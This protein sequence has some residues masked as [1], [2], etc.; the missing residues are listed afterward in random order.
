MSIN[1]IPTEI[2][3]KILENVP[4]K[5]ASS[6]LR[7]NREW[8]NVYKYILQRDEVFELILYTDYENWEIFHSKTNAKYLKRKVINFCK[9]F[10]INHRLKLRKTLKLLNDESLKVDELLKDKK[11]KDFK[12]NLM[13]L[14]DI[15][16]KKMQI[17]RLFG[18]PKYLNL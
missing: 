7:V 1:T 18:C 10:G 9:A 13:K 17:E 3:V 5:D 12:K 4:I 16:M 14:H 11:D 8:N 6:V 15:I 2:F